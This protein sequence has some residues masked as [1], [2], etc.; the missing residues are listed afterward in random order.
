MFSVVYVRRRVM[1]ARQSAYS[2]LQST[3]SNPD[4][5]MAVGGRS[6]R[7]RGRK[8]FGA[9]WAAG[10]HEH[11]GIGGAAGARAAPPTTSTSS[12]PT[13][14]LVAARNAARYSDV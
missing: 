11:T 10:R 4:R 2:S 5:A 8:A 3:Y 9:L 6:R 14:D 13:G 12:L 7:R 1:E